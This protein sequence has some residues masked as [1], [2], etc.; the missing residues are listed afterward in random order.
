MPWL[1]AAPALRDVQLSGSRS[2]SCL[3]LPSLGMK[4][5][6]SEIGFEA[7]FYFCFLTAA[8]QGS[9][10]RVFDPAMLLSLNILKRDC[11]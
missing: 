7:V 2:C 5:Q 3:T 8:V 4:G 9:R 6:D 10:R 1:A 11:L